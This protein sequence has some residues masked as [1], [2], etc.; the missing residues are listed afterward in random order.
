MPVGLYLS[1]CRG[2]LRVPDVDAL[3]ERF[4]D[5]VDVCRVV[6][7]FFEPGVQESIVAEIRDRGLGGVVLAGNS[8]E[9]HMRSLSG[10]RLQDSIVEAGVNP[11]RIAFANLLEQVALPH[12]VDES[13][14]A[15]KA[16]V[17][18]EDAIRQARTFPPVEAVEIVPNRSVLILGVTAA[19][20]VAA[21]RLLRLGYGVTI[22]DAGAVDRSLSVGNGL[23][24]TGA[25]VA[26]HPAV[27][28][29]ESAELADAEGWLGDYDVTFSTPDGS[30]PIRAGGILVADGAAWVEPL[31]RHYALAVDD[32]GLPLSLGAAHPARTV[33]PG[34]MLM[35]AHD[36][37]DVTE[38]IRAA[39]VAA[40]ALV[41]HLSVPRVLRG[42]ATSVVDESLCG[43][44][45]SCVKTCAFGA[46]SIDPETR[47]SHVDPRRCHGCGKC[48]VSCPVGARDIVSSPHAQMLET[49]RAMAASELPAPRVLGFLCGGCG[50][51]AADEAG[52]QAAAGRET[53]PAS[54]LPIR[55]PCGGRL[56][57]LYVL[58]AIAAGFD[59]VAVFR[60]R[61]GHCRNLV[62]NLDMDRRINLLRT[63]LRSRAIDDARL[64]IIDISPEEGELFTREVTAFFSQLE[65]MSTM[66]GGA[67]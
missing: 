9:H 8:V 16:A 17:L 55:I 15:T 6:D 64:S 18:L 43:G 14:A 11:N 56:D 21:Q 49:I 66:E 24:A 35:P 44:C 59:G 61:E 26:S 40:L 38:V 33:D 7:D 13:G 63:V 34:I 50:Y 37:G 3:A 58:E 29:V 2:A 31:R 62:G 10:P 27:S 46:C 42:V 30:R 12:S 5:S 54:F 52:R 67:R 57:A 51:P 53:Y 22:A 47:L 23:R 32:D 60:C 48:V 39:D 4:G 28:I 36:D 1:R 19:A 41:L 45:A 65:P 20:V 25:F